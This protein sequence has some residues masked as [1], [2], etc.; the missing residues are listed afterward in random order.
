[1]NYGS[2]GK[3]TFPKIDNINY[4]NDNKSVVMEVQLMPN[5]EYQFI[6]TG[7]NFKTPEVIG[8]KTYEV[9]FKTAK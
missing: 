8:L 3:F 7:K 1:V 9:N 5:Q 4:M 2:K 6:L